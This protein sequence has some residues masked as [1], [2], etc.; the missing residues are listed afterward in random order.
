MNSIVLALFFLGALSFTIGLLYIQIVGIYHS[1]KANVG[2]GLVSIFVAPFAL[3]VGA[4]SSSSSESAG[5]GFFRP[6]AI[7]FVSARF[8]AEA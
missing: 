3:A 7:V 6:A 8:V 2:L 5:E 4:D 1:F